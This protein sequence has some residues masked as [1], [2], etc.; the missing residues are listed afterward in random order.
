MTLTTWLS[1]QASTAVPIATGNAHRPGR[2][3]PALLGLVAGFAVL[4]APASARVAGQAE[5]GDRAMSAAI[6]ERV[7]DADECLDARNSTCVIDTLTPLLS[8]EISAFERFVL[9]RM[10]GVAHYQ[11]GQVAAAIQDFEAALETGVATAE[12][13]ARLRVNIGQL[14]LIEARPDEGIEQLEAAVEAGLPEDQVMALM[15]AQAYA[16]AER[17]SEGLRHAETQYQQAD[18][19]VRRNYDMLLHYYQQLDRVSDQIDMVRAMMARW[20]E[21]ERLDAMLAR[22]TARGD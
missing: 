9:L 2:I 13:E 1:E 3:R 22:L 20:P 8:G 4:A 6:G 7:Q 18:P 14:H 12:E 21:D 16:Q 10:R 17:Y 5:T 19:R 15:L 11:S